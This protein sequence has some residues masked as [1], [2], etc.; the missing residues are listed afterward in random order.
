MSFVFSVTS[1]KFGCR[2][3]EGD[4]GGAEN[5]LPTTGRIARHAFTL[6]GVLTPHRFSFYRWN[7]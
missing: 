3:K 5:V 6:D 7:N 1:G 2:M 4:G